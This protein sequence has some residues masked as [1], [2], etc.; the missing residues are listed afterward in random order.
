MLFGRY[1]DGDETSPSLSL[2]DFWMCDQKR[3]VWFGMENSHFLSWVRGTELSLS[4]F[5]SPSLSLS[6]SH[7]CHL[8]CDQKSTVWVRM[9]NSHSVSWLRG[10]QL[11]LSL[12]LSLS[13]FLSISLLTFTLWSEKASLGQDGNFSFFKFSEGYYALSLSLG[14]SLGLR[15]LWSDKSR[16]DWVVQSSFW[17]L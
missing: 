14:L 6:H 7:F 15:N 17:K 3:E 13:L 9:D 5:L 1:V 10:I 12:S 2:W 16:L 11:S 4:F 8:Y